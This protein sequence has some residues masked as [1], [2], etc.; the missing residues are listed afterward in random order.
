[1]ESSDVSEGD[2]PHFLYCTLESQESIIEGVWK[3]I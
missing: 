2:Y 3:L 1:M